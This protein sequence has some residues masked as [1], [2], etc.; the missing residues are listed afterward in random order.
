MPGK[1]LNC[2]QPIP[3]PYFDPPKAGRQGGGKLN[4]IYI[5]FFHKVDDLGIDDDV[6]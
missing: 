2:F 5:G 3:N 6:V 4:F 1:N